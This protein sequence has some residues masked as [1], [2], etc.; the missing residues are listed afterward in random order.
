[1]SKKNFVRRCE[2]LVKPNI[3]RIISLSLS[4]YCAIDFFLKLFSIHSFIH[5]ERLILDGVTS[6]NRLVQLL[7]SLVS[8]PRLFTL[9]ITLSSY[10]VD[11]NNIL[12]CIF[13]LPV[14]NY[15]KLKF[16]E[17]L[18]RRSLSCTH[19]KKFQC[20]TLKYLVID[21]DFCLNQL[22][23]ILTYTPQLTYLSC[24]FRSGFDYKTNEQLLMP[25]YLT[26]ISLKFHDVSFDEIEKF[27]SKIS[28]QLQ[29]LR[30]TIH[31]NN[32]F[33]CAE[34]WEQLITNHMPH[35]YMFDFM[36]LIFKYYSSN[37]YI[38]SNQLFDRFKSSFWKNR[39]WFFQYQHWLCDNDDF[40]GIF[41]STH[42]YR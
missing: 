3:T 26:D 8:L 4:N 23:P 17:N 14:V 28:H 32:I 35:L 24:R 25:Y 22:T 31:M 21:G 15:C 27:L 10:Y 11:E 6:N 5:L 30:L 34:R 7:N 33:L 39:N 29:R 12:Q 2:E 38:I 13:R 19:D 1:M 9:S 18:D 16:R 40:S 42:P 37:D 41:Y 20:Q 36:Y